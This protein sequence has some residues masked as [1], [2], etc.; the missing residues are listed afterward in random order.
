MKKFVVGLVASALVFG[1]IGIAFFNSIKEAHQDEKD[2][3]GLKAVPFSD[4]YSSTD[5]SS[6]PVYSTARPFSFNNMNIGTSWNNYRGETLNGDPVVVAVID[7]GADIY[8]ED[9]L[10]PEAKN[11]TI[12]SSNIANYSLLNPKSC[13]IH[14]PSEGSYTSSVVTDVGIQYAHDTDTYDSDYDEYYSHGTAS[15]SCIGAAV[16]GVGSL[17]I[18]PNVSLMIIRIDFWFTSLDVAVRY[19]ADNGAKVINMSLGAYAETFNDGYGDKQS[20]SSSTAT[21]LSS[22][23]SYA[24]N[25]DVVVVAAAGNEKTDHYSY[26]ACNDGVIGVGALAR[27]SSTS[28]ADFSNYNK[29]TDT[30]TGNHNVDVSAPGYVYTANVNESADYKTS[31]DL[32]DNYYYETQ[33]T[34]FACPLTAGAVALARAKWPE[35]T[36]TEIEQKLFDSCYDIGTTGWDKNFGY[37]RVDVTKLLTENT[38][39]SISLSPSERNLSI[40]DTLQLEVNYEPASASNKTVMFL[41]EDE[42]VATVDEDTGL[43][44]AFGNGVTRIGC[45]P[46]ETGVDEAYMTV[47]VGES[48]WTEE[49]EV[50]SCTWEKVTSTSGMVSG[51]EYIFGNYSAGKV[52]GRL[53]SGSYL[54]ALS[55]TFDSAT[56]ISELPD[57]YESFIYN[58]T[59]S[60]FTLT[61]TSNGELLGYSGTSLS[62]SGST[63]WSNFTISSGDCSF[64]GGSNYFSYNSSSPRW[65]TYGSSQGTFEIYVKTESSSGSGTVTGISLN[66]SSTTLTAGNNET[67]VATV[68]GTGN[69]DSTVTWTTSNSSVA[70]VNNGVVTALAAGTA[71]ITASAGGYQATCTVTVNAANVAVTSVSL[72]QS[73]ASLQ[74][75]NTLTLT[76]TVSPSNATNKNVTWTSSNTSVATVSSSGVVTAVAAGTSTI[77]V[78]TVDGNK[79][80]TCTVTVTSSTLIPSGDAMEIVFKTGSGD[81]TE[82]STSTLKSNFVSEGAS[83][84]SSISSTSKAYAAGSDGLKLGTSSVAGSL[85]LVLSSEVAATTIV[86]NAKLYNSGKAATLNVNGAGAQSLTASFADYTYNI[87][88]SIT[89]LSLNSSKYV[90]VSGVTINSEDT[91]GKIVQSLS[92]SYTGG[93]VYVGKQLDTS[94]VSVTASFTDS[95]N[96]QDE[97]L[98]SD[99]Y[100]LTGFDSSS[101]KVSTVTVTYTGNLETYNNQTITTSFNVSIVEDSVSSISASCNKTFYVGESIAKSDISVTATHLSGDTEPVTNFTFS[102][103]GYQFTYADAP[104]GGSNGNKVFN[105]SY[106]GKNTTVTVY[107]SRSAYVA[108]SSSSLTL[109]GTQAKNAGITGTGASGIADYVGEHAITI[110]GVKC[111][112]HNVYVYTTNNINYIS[113]GQTTGDI[114]NVEPLSKPIDTLTIDHR[115]GART[116]EKI[117]ISTDGSNWVTYSTATAQSGDYRY[118]KIAYE[119]SS[120]TYSNFNNINFSLRGVDNALNVANYIM[121][122]DTA[123]QCLTKLNDVLLKLNNMSNE[124]KETFHTS[125]D[126]VIA[127]ARERLEAW[128]RHEGKTLS[129][130]DNMF[131]INTNRPSMYQTYA[132]LDAIIFVSIIS[133]G[134]FALFTLLN[135]KRKE[136]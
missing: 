14:D 55:A 78:R 19:A 106:Q 128:A 124:E 98:S 38:L 80:A 96:F 75:G 132:Y 107:V 71:T 125:N 74:V 82:M 120:S 15:A 112:A 133:I 114:Y 23:I 41:S 2:W 44:T 8:H 56:S 136:Q 123:N 81:G 79:T 5:Y 30:A 21:A 36:H 115:S 47:N 50:H 95:S 24:H 59:T 108:P 73:S 40:G 33:G 92:V 60:S 63:T 105:I 58:G 49:G 68:T 90:W 113:M 4:R 51:K 43:V 46:D 88:G 101:V 135:K 119:S 6:E 61:Q 32:K 48:N 69:Y 121:Y 37:G 84:I 77:T 100:S 93:D 130:E 52:S 34:S 66:K 13:Y 9:F 126:Y 20:G 86:V 127:T 99:K 25:K 110:N 83:Y 11:V 65:K 27:Q 85:N 53:G 104:S 67:L 111:E 62:S 97:V 22:A 76:A 42:S 54:P 35:M 70:T 72:S 131:V 17:G 10:K 117:Y 91:E 28:K 39:E 1:G 94:K 7:S 102:E 134:G 29:S 116:D 118:F 87:N 64:K 109:T 18:A 12:T 3:G 45:L 31:G 57:E 129:L 16:N 89:S 122:E 26:P 103:D